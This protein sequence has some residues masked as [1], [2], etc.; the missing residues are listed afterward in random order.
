M[1]EDI[2][3]EASRKFWDGFADRYEESALKLTTPLYRLL[4][5]LIQLN[6]TIDTIIEAGCGPGNGLQIL[7]EIVPA[8]IKILSN[9]ISANMISKARSRCLENVEI[10]MASNDSLPYND[11]ICDRYISNLTL[12]L[13]EDAPSMLRE[14]FRLLKPGG[15]AIFSVWGKED[16]HNIFKIQGRALSNAGISKPPGRTPFYLNNDSELLHLLVDAGFRQVRSFYTAI[17]DSS[18]NAD[19]FVNAYRSDPGIA[20]FKEKSLETYEKILQFLQAEAQKSF[21]SGRVITFDALVVV[22]VKIS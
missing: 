10:I 22:G 5:P 2:P 13:V 11:G 4:I 20:A 14:A 3:L 17:G 15:I 12:H 9:D 19:E 6:E 8:S 21:D 18:Q 1:G 16:E 7:R